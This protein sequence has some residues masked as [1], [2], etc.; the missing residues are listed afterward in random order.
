MN[1]RSIDVN[2]I[3][4]MAVDLGAQMPQRIRSAHEAAEQA[5][6][7]DAAA[8]P[9]QAESTASK[10]VHDIDAVGAE[11]RVQLESIVSRVVSAS[12]A[13]RGDLLGEVID[14]VVADRLQRD[15]LDGVDEF[16]HQ[17]AEVMRADPIVVAELDDILQSIARELAWREA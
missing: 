16:R 3:A 8:S 13:E 9:P 17:V 12:Q 5:P 2:S 10:P 6:V 1:I 15:G 7:A 11:L 4:D 14:V